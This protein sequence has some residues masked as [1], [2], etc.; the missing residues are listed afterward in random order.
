MQLN[1]F[2]RDLNSQ[3]IVWIGF[4]EEKISHLFVPRMKDN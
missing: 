2:D 4:V 3:V 1:S